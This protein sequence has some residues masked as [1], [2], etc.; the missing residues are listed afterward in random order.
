[1]KK[2][3]WGLVIII[4][5]AGVGFGIWGFAKAQKSK[6]QGKELE[7]ITAGVLVLNKIETEDVEVSLTEWKNLS[8]ADPSIK[9]E[10]EKV[11]SIPHSLQNKMNEFFSAQPADK[12]EE[13][14]YLQLLLD[15]Q[16]Q[17]D[18]KN[19]QAKSKRQIEE[20]VKAIDNL[21]N[22]INQKGLSLGPEYN[23]TMK[24]LETEAEAF[25]ANCNNIISKTAYDS[26]ATQLRTAGF[27]KAFDVLKLTIIQSLNNYVDLQDSIKKEI[28]D[29]ANS[30]WINPL[31]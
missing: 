6:E 31:R 12:Y 26:P 25:K 28:A 19:Q 18:L 8:E 30:N 24:A 17:L 29:L 11:S 2:F 14:Q 9:D 10:L 21:Q 15:G 4:I 22:E 3:V 1:M 20:I 5:L 7:R 23:Q 16:R 27:D 13:V